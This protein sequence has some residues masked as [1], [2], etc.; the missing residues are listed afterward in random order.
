MGWLL[1]GILGTLI[2]LAI[3]VGIVVLVVRLVSGRNKAT[4]EGV[5]VLIR[6]V[7]VYAIMLVM[8]VLV[9]IGVA[10]LIQAAWPGFNELT[11]SSSKTAISIAFVIVG[12]PVYAGLAL[13]TKRLLRD[14]P[15]E[16]RSVGWVFYLT[17]A[18]VGSLLASMSLIGGV[19]SN[20]A[21]DG[22]IDRSQLIHAVVWTA[23]WVGHWWVAQRWEPKR[24]TQIHLLLGS[25]VGLIWTFTGA[26]AT[27]AAVLS[28]VYD[29]L[30]LVSLIDG[31]IAVLLRPLTVLL[32]GAPVWWWYWFRHTRQG[33]RTPWWL[34]HVLLLGV[35]GGA[36]S[37]ITGAGV[38]LFGV[39]EWILGD[40]ASSAAAHFTFL[41]GAITGMVVGGG[42]WAY[43]AAILGSRDETDRS[44]VGRVY[45]YLLAGA[46]LVVAASG[47][48]TL[49]TTAIK[50]ASGVTIVSSGGGST[51]AAAITLIVIGTPLW[52]RYWSTIQRARTEDPVVELR[53]ITRRIYIVVL[54]GVAAVVAVVSLIVLV[55]TVFEDI[56]DGNFGSGTVSSTAV[57]VALLLTAGALAWYHLTVFREDRADLVPEVDEVPAEPETPGPSVVP[58]GS[59]EQALQTLAESGH[60][61]STVVRT[62]DGFEVEPLDA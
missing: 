37:A 22:D 27:I 57:P 61:R 9:G 4:S 48:T 53:S 36:V 26:F 50:S 31:G 46:G 18:L 23:I 47:I 8:L 15:R 32:V 29:S 28:T 16:Q 58:R 52:W 41:P 21:S 44:E 12:L 24:N 39:L 45:D 17:A 19:L 13:Y 62:E 20:L 43:H 2:Q 51:L 49:I 34:A 54:F 56:L 60:G 14:D 30:F 59:L 5:G 1:L 11:D 40:P 42:T 10:G 55:F 7:F 33:T 25:A 35:L 6:R 38:L 3:I